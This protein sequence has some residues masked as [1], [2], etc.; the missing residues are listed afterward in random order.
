VVGAG[1]AVVGVNNDGEIAA[2][3]F[4]VAPAA[5]VILTA[6]GMVSPTA[7]VQIGKASS[8]F[9]TGAGDLLGLPT[10]AF[11]TN[12]AASVTAGFKPALPVSVTVA[13]IPVF[14]QTAATAPGQAGVL[15]VVFV[16]PASVPTGTQTIA[17]TLGGITATA[18]IVVQ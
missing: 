14:V 15:Q 5:P 10:T 7:T 2:Y 18:Q 6:E 3:A 12:P 9:L 1:P 8:L 4:Q 11:T 16:L 17:V 13:G